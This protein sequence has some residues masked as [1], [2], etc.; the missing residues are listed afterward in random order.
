MIQ[1][2]DW[3]WCGLV[4]PAL[5]GH[6]RL[7]QNIGVVDAHLF[8]VR[9]V[10]ILDQEGVG[11]RIVR[12]KNEL[13]D[14]LGVDSFPFGRV[15]PVVEG[16][17]DVEHLCP[18]AAP[19]VFKIQRV[20]KKRIEQVRKTLGKFLYVLTV[21]DRNDHVGAVQLNELRS[22]LPINEH[23]RIEAPAPHRI[24]PSDGPAERF[25]VAG[26]NCPRDA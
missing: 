14:T 12:V 26:M 17:L 23:D 11:Q 4:D 1:R 15:A 18:R 8:R 2:I 20:G 22:I 9:I 10:A 19:P 7:R 25:A 6:R 13:P 24:R 5:N 16:I 3:N 21:T